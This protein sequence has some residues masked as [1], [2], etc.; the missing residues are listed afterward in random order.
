MPTCILACLLLISCG[1]KD[2]ETYASDINSM[3]V[4]AMPPGKQ[5]LED[6][7]GPVITIDDTRALAGPNNM[8]THE[9]VEIRDG[10]LLK[11][12]FKNLLVF[13]ADDT[14]QVN[15]SYLTTLIMAKN[16]V[17]G[18][19]KTEA[20]ESSNAT[21]NKIYLDSSFEIGTRMKAKLLDMNSSI[22]KG[23]EIENVG[24]PDAEIQSLG[25]GRDKIYWQWKITPLKEGLQELKLVVNV[26]EKDGETVNLPTRSIPVIIFAE[27][28]SWTSST[29]SFFAK[30]FQWMITAILIPLL[31]AYITT[32][33]KN[34]AK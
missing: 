12:K 4:Q 33:I 24:G 34:K 10:E 29:G 7:Q 26:I 8:P 31:I 28:T 19:V 11:R 21:D 20:L 27:K 16:N 18:Q 32:R 1:T 17:L 2:G 23:F 22:D 6:E 14:M 13:H 9:S 25:K 15:K 3:E 30:N 5:V